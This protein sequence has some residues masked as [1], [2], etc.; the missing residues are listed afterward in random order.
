MKRCPKMNRQVTSKIQLH[1]F[2]YPLLLEQS[3]IVRFLIHFILR[4][5]RPGDKGW[6]GRARVPLPSDKDYVN[7]PKWKTDVDMS[8]VSI[9]FE[10]YM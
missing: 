1:I 8:R 10:L 5:L 4:P 2:T 3:L 6:I 7:R 9:C